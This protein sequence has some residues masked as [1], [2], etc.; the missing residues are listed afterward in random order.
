MQQMHC[1]K[2]MPVWQSETIPLA[3][4]QRHNTKEGVWAKLTI[5]QG[6]LTFAL[7]DEHDAVI[8]SE[9]YSVE[10]QPPMVQPQQWHRIAAYSADIVCQLTFY[11]Q[12]RLLSPEIRTHPHTFGGHQRGSLC[13][14]R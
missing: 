1:Y 14:A 2:T 11:C 8:N 10:R 4:Q 12:P 13:F 7:L 6:T 3:F 9:E 5:L